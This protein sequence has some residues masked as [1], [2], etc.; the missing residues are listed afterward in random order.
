MKTLPTALIL[1]CLGQWLSLQAK[2]DDRLIE[3]ASF[4]E[5]QVTGIGVSQKTG[6]IFVNFPYWSDRYQFA[7]GELGTDGK[8]KQYPDKI[9]NAKEGNPAK[10]FV[11]VQSVVVD[12]Q[13][14][15]WVLDPASPKQDGVVPN[16]AKLVEIDLATNKVIRVYPFSDAVAPKKSYLNDVRIDTQ[17]EVAYMT[18]SGVGSIVVLD[19]KTG[20]ARAVLR[21]HYSTKAETTTDMVIDGIRPLDIKTGTI[22]IF[23][24]DGIALDRS[25]GILYYHPLTAHAMYKVATADLL[26]EKLSDE[27]LG[28]KVTKVADTKIP[29]G[30]LEEPN[31]GVIL[32][33][34]EENSVD[35]ID[36][37]SGSVT[38][39]VQDDRLQW[40]DTMAWGA[41]HFLYVTASQIHRMP[42]N[43][44]GVNKQKG[45]FKVF[46]IQV[47]DK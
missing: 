23:N 45:P 37:T 21:R 25:K 17:A 34:I 12:D 41:D 27:E 13:D 9:W 30:M 35:R 18:E 22:P 46:K 11:C 14:H 28:K 42:N 7:V 26:D 24:A 47:K 19:L 39:I 15:L 33:D 16:G 29:D 36:P 10:R 40:P 38:T 32:T 43:N 31:G 2:G 20:N 4:P 44:A 1:I 3:V 5:Q 6:R 8:L